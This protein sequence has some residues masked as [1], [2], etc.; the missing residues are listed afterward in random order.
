MACGNEAPGGLMF[1]HWATANIALE[2]D[3]PEPLRCPCFGWRNI[4]VYWPP[5]KAVAA[6]G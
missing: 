6:A 5:S 1:G 4:V 3:A 2:A